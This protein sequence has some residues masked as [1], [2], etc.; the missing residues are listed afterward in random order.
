MGF[1]GPFCLM[2]INEC[3]SHPCLNKGSC[4][5]SLGKYRCICPLGYTGKNCQVGGNFLSVLHSQLLFELYNSRS[6]WFKC[7]IPNVASAISPSILISLL[8]QGKL[9]S[10][11]LCSRADASVLVTT[12][13]RS[14]GLPCILRF[15]WFSFS[16]WAQKPPTRA[17]NDWLVPVKDSCEFDCLPDIQRKTVRDELQIKWEN[18]ILT[19][20]Q[21]LF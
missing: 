9:S 7:E 13:I 4:V 21:F 3:D 5:D 16:Q 19:A 20:F 11:S 2:E 12:S 14:S 1:T 6:C 10:V 8:A 15:R 18:G 17:V